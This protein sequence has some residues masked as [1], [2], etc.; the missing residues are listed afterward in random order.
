MTSD[1][2]ESTP[3]LLTVE[4]AVAT[5]R[6]NRR[7]HLNRIEPEDLAALH[8]LLD[9]VEAAPAIRVLVLTGTGRA[10]SAGYHLG[11]IAARQAAPAADEAP[12]GSGFQRLADRLE[13]LAVPTV[14]RL[15]GSVYGGA[16]DLA[17]ACDFRIGVEG[18]EVLAMGYLTD[19][20]L[21]EALDAAVAALA[22]ILASNAPGAVRGM[23][24]T[25]NAI[26]HGALDAEA[27]RARH[28]DSLRGP[29]I[30]EGPRAFAAKRPPVFT[31]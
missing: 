19:L 11:D 21:A 26:A 31:G 4:G 5:I 6:L 30:E 9:A 3:P 16:T 25:I 14:G 1:A 28:R 22:A 20:V 10:F 17:L 2:S 18:S 12:A 24:R 8:A 13:D 15:N 27:A 23:K 7:R 29:E